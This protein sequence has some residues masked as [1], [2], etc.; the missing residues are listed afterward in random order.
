MCSSDNDLVGQ[1]ALS[2]DPADDGGL[3]PR[4]REEGAVGVR[5]SGLVGVALHQV[6]EVLGR[7]NT[8]GG[9]VVPVKRDKKEGKEEKEGKERRAIIESN[10]QKSSRTSK[11]KKQRY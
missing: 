9:G 11:Q 1:G 2:L 6:A 10:A 4:V 3:L 5:A 8:S 7:L